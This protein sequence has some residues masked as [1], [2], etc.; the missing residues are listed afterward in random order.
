MDPASPTHHV[1]RRQ[2]HAAAALA[3]AVV[4]LASLGV[5]AVF[6]STTW[7]RNLY[8]RNGV[9]FQDP[10]SAACTAAAA[11]MMLNFTALR[12]TGG[13][14]FIWRTNKTHNSPDPTNYRDMTSILYFERMHDTLRSSTTGSD[15]HGWRNALNYYGWGA[16]ALNDATKRVYDDLQ[17]TSSGAAVK[18]AVRA[19]ARFNKPV[20]I[21]GW[22]GKHAQ[23][24]TGYVVSGANPAVSNDFT[25]QYVYLTDPLKSDGFVNTK[26]SLR[27]FQSGNLHYRFQAYRES[28]SPYDDSY[29]SGWRRSSVLPTVGTSEWYRRWVIIA[30][31]RAGLADSSSPNPTPSPTPSASAESTSIP[32]PSPTSSPTASSDEGVSV[33]SS[34]SAGPVGQEPSASPDPTYSPSA[35]EPSPAPVDEPAT[36]SP[37]EEAADPGPSAVP[38]AS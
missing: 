23:V 6:G 8:N 31:I 24:M 35:T 1:R 37:S 5:N 32:S 25:V 12:E 22:A 27:A 10:Y 17:Y 7:S 36:P 18:A 3:V 34:P 11:M 19:I 2:R 9:I 33:A 13:E 20:G 16:T 4:I 28:D 38:S 30:P 26:I 29:S 21:L 14:G 15:P